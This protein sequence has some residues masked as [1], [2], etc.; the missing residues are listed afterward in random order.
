MSDERGHL[1]AEHVTW[2]VVEN[3]SQT[4]SIQTLKSN[5]APALNHLLTVDIIAGSC[6]VVSLVLLHWYKESC[7]DILFFWLS[8]YNS[9]TV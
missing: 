5:Q 2:D 7:S 9:A 6:L 1:N 3:L 8:M 4:K